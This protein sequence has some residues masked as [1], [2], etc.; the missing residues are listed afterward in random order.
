MNELVRLLKTQDCNHSKYLRVLKMSFLDLGSEVFGCLFENN[1]LVSL[2]ESLTSSHLQ[3]LKEAVYCLAH[4]L[5]N[6]Q[7]SVIQYHRKLFQGLIQVCWTHK[8]PHVFRLL[9]ELMA[10]IIRKKSADKTQAQMIYSLLKII[11]QLVLVDDMDQLENNFLR[12]SEFLSKL[13][14]ET[15]RGFMNCLTQNS[16][17]I[18]KHF[19]LSFHQ[20]IKSLDKSI[21]GRSFSFLNKIENETLM[22]DADHSEYSLQNI[23]QQLFENQM[24]LSEE[25]N[26][27]KTAILV[28]LANCLSQ[29][30]QGCLSRFMVYEFSFRFKRAK[31]SESQKSFEFFLYQIKTLKTSFQQKTILVWILNDGL[32]L[33]IQNLFYFKNA[34]FLKNNSHLKKLL[35]L[36]IKQISMDQVKEKNS[37]N[38]KFEDKLFE[39]WNNSLTIRIVS[40][41]LTNFSDTIPKHLLH[42][43][44]KSSMFDEILKEILFSGRSQKSFKSLSQILKQEL[45]Q[46]S[47]DYSLPLILNTDLSSNLIDIIL[48]NI[49]SGILNNTM[50]FLFNSLL[51]KNHHDNNKNSVSFEETRTEEIIKF[52]SEDSTEK[53]KYEFKIHLETDTLSSL[54]ILSCFFESFPLLIIPNSIKKTFDQLLTNPSFLIET[55][56]KLAFDSIETKLKFKIQKLML[57]QRLLELKTNTNCELSNKAN[58]IINTFLN[59]IQNRN[60]SYEVVKDIAD[61]IF[62]CLNIQNRFNLNL[63]SSFHTLYLDSV[64]ILLKNPQK[65]QR[66]KGIFMLQ[67]LNLQYLHQNLA[68]LKNNFQVF[69]SKSEEL[70][71]LKANYFTKISDEESSF[72][73]LSLIQLI[74]DVK[75]IV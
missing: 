68:G 8:D 58:I 29:S 69:N 72:S 16:Q 74:Q 53:Y 18:L 20:L 52:I 49:D 31:K 45:K 9:M 12:L 3:I 32:K 43:L 13:L 40:A 10:Y 19:L 38:T 5:K 71:D 28:R 6:N 50:E 14:F 26:K 23:K 1:L 57:Q 65:G 36:E 33:S 24:D 67:K 39:S 46:K 35:L 11:W 15:L 30:L 73:K 48:D 42:Y 27:Y 34:F 37:I 60:H 54:Y 55:N 2:L 75:F 7:K 66:E 56:D 70:S 51:F 4:I 21:S 64:S 47:K 44:A 63:N 59:E 25:G 62:F 61:L 22:S 41:F 17:Q